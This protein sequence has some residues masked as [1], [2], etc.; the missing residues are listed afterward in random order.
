MATLNTVTANPGTWAGSTPISYQYQWQLCASNGGSCHDIGGATSQTYTIKSTDLGSTLRVT[1][2]AGNSDG[3]N[4]AQSAATAQ[5]TAAPGP[6]N[7]ALPS[8]SGST[9]VGSTLTAATGTWTG[10]N[11]ITYAYQWEICGGDGNACSNISGATNSTFQLRP[12][13]PGNT[14]RVKVTATD[15]TGPNS[16]TSAATAQITAAVPPPTGCPA[17]AAGANAVAIAGVSSPARLQIASFT[18]APAVVAGSS[19]S[20]NV[21]FHITDTCGQAVQGAFVYA[22]AVPYAQFSIPGQGTTDASGNVTL[23]FSRLHGFPTSKSQRLLVMFVR[24]SRAGDPVLAGIST[25]RLISL[26]VD[27]KS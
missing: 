17:L 14:V 22:T 21:S 11:P 18:P 2:I 6:T 9:S 26:R 20:L 10:N 7:T 13:D 4:P 19:S 12:Q 5:I 25:R 16:A 15:S 8:I 23:Q 24:A 3:S 27:L 1:V